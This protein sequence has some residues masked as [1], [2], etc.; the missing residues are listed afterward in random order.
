M[1]AEHEGREGAR[2]LIRKSI[3]T[4]WSWASLC[5]AEPSLTTTGIGLRPDI[6]RLWAT[7]GGLVA[8]RCLR[9]ML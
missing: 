5:P 9:P 4:V 8:P 6:G 3:L 7:V 1:A 2:R